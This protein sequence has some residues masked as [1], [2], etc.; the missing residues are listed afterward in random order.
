SAISRTRWPPSSSSSARKR[1]GAWKSPTCLIPSSATSDRLDRELSQSIEPTRYPTD[2]PRSGSADGECEGQHSGGAGLTEHPRRDG[3]GPAGFD[4]VV[5]QQ[6]RP[7][8]LAR[9]GGDVFGKT[10][11]APTA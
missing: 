9:R 3:H 4:P 5:D 1:C 7:P 10:E 2:L 8:E 6:H 11:L